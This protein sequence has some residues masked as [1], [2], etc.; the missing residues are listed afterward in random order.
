MYG[1]KN[2]TVRSGFFKNGWLEQSLRLD[3][4]AQEY[5]VKTE[6]PYYVAK[7]ASIEVFGRIFGLNEN[8]DDV[9]SHILANTELF[10][11]KGADSV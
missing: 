6:N 5:M 1:H 2:L 7:M 10:Q 9:R 4:K 11:P 3:R 8:V